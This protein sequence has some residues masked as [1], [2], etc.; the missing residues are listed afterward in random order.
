M[1]MSTT[2]LSNVERVN[3][4]CEAFGLAPPFA[5]EQVAEARRATTA[6]VARQKAAGVG[7]AVTAPILPRESVFNALVEMAR[8]AGAGEVKS[9]DFVGRVVETRKQVYGPCVDHPYTLAGAVL[10]FLGLTREV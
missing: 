10:T 6:A 7:P 3:R 5:Q 4:M 2:P 9:V 8:E 1:P